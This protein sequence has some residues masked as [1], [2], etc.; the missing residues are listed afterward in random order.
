MK[1][2]SNKIKTGKY[3]SG[4]EF[5]EEITNKPYQGY[6]Y[7][8]NNSLYAGKEFKDDAPK[9]IKIQDANK[10]YYKNLDTAT[11]SNLSGITSQQLSSPKVTGI[12]NTSGS[13]IRYF[14]K[15]LNNNPILIKEI[16]K[17][18]YNSLQKDPIYQ[19]I[20]I[21]LPASDT[22][23]PNVL[24]NANK[25]MPGLKPFILSSFPPDEEF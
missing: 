11:F 4:G 25:Q 9:I 15:K 14:A 6:Y 16:D 8:L 10:M 7:E 19:T 5:V 21:N 12:V 2:P 18:T 1:I 3:T 24:D 22:P 20:I 23:D 13:P 17:D